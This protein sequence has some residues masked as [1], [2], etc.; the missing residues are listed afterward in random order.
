MIQGLPFQGWAKSVLSVVNE[1]AMFNGSGQRIDATPYVQAEQ[2]GSKRQ[3]RLQWSQP[4][5]GSVSV[6]ARMDRPQ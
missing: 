2:G 3:L 6:Y 5:R 4:T 1:S